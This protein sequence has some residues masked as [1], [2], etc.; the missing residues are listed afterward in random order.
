VLLDDGGDRL[1]DLVEGGLGT[2]G[3]VDRE[4][5]GVLLHDLE[6][7]RAAAGVR[8]PLRE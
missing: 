2:R 6:G 1:L 3:A 7:L 8:E 5:V 4:P